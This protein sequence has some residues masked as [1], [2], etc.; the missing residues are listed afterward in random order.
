VLDGEPNRFRPVTGLC[1][2]VP[3][4]LFFQHAPEALSEKRM[5]V[6]KDDA[7]SVHVSSS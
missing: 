4:G 2:Y 1:D 5:V 3:P 6:G 7:Q